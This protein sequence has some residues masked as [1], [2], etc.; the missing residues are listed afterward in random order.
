MDRKAIETISVN[1]VRDSIVVS[2]FLDQ[3]ISDN[4]KEPS[5]DGYV[6]I[7]QDKSKTKAKLK[8]RLPVQVKGT[9]N[10]DFSKDEISFSVSTIDLNNYLSDGGAVFFVVYIGYN[11][12]TKQIYYAELTPIKLRILLSEA[13]KQK[14]KTI[15]L[16]KFPDDPNQKASIFFN[17]LENCQKQASFSNAKLL[18]LEELEKQGVLEGITI[19]VS[20]VGNIT[21]Q[22]ALVTSEVYLY[23]KIKGSAIPQPIEVLPQSLCTREERDAQIT[24]GDR[25]FYTSVSVIRDAET[26]KTLVGESFSITAKKSNHPVK[27][28][29]NGSSKLRVL[30]RDLEFM[31]SYI[32]NGSF[33]YNGVPFPFDK[34][35]ADF[36]NFSIEAESNRLEYCKK[37]I[38][39]LDLLNCK[40]DLDLKALRTTDWRNIN[41]L[42]TALIDKKPIKNLKA[43]LQPVMYI[44]VGPLRFIMCFF[45]NENESGTYEIAD[46]FTTDLAIAYDT[47]KNEKLPVS[48][49][50]ILHA[51]DFNKADNIRFDAFFPSFQKTER[52]SETMIRANFF[53]LDLLEAYDISQNEEILNTAESFSDWLMGATEEELPYALRLLNSLQITKR[54]RALKTD[55]VKELYRLIETQ[56][57]HED[58]VVGA[59]LLL[60]QQAAAEMHFEKMSKKSQEEFK[61]YPIYHFWNVGGK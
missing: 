60:D 23:A 22:A 25:L 37:I 32:K 27:I 56:A 30:A 54:K 11:G 41:S 5:W 13:G 39:V 14:H 31:L 28:N 43:N 40:K 26:V 17:C 16:K 45:K 10:N 47:D 35:S 55:E 24:V 29:Y 34:A 21:P 19:P 36:G 12:L 20:T 46:F 42:I 59:Y 49:Y 50:A 61:K 38:Q 51:S 3:F 57:A 15:Q 1:A 52:H 4:D 48:Q 58:V 6:Y 9:E 2:D 18:S 53:L 8:G 7:Y 33:S 44:N